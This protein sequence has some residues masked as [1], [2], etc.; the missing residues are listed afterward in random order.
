MI[1]IIIPVYEN[2]DKIL[3]TLF[4]ICIQT[5]KE[6]IKVYII[7]IGTN[8]EYENIK[9][10][11][12]N[13]LNITIV[14][15]EKICKLGIARNKGIE[16]SKNPYIFFL[17]SG[18]KIYH[19]YSLEILL[20]SIED[21]DI[22][23]G[24]ATL[25]KDDETVIYDNSIKNSLNSKLYKREFII[26]N[27]IFFNSIEKY[28]ELSFNILAF[29]LTEKV[30]FID[31]YISLYKEGNYVINDLKKYIENME[32]LIKE[33]QKRNLSKKIIALEANSVII[34][35]YFKYLKYI[36]YNG[37]E[38]LFKWLNNIKNWYFEYRELV[39]TE[40]I[41]KEYLFYYNNQDCIIPNLSLNDFIE[42][43]YL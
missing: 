11:F 17:N 7:D 41:E 21:N 24:I 15:L 1:D 31:E 8:N 40:E 14:H 37:I 43:I 4:S 26:N 20:N 32:W 13:K 27:N 12:K 39:T 19:G 22:A 10:I 29:K 18:D 6:K 28:N 38:E 36:R 42:K 35:T 33:Y 16:I 23:Y 30:S 25:A 5:I 2:Y 9:K 34:Y 3:K